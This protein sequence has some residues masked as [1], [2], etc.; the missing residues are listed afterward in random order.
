MQALL[1][2]LKGAEHAAAQSATVWAVN[3]LVQG[4]KSILPELL[5]AGTVETLIHC[6]QTHNGAAP[7]AV[8][9]LLVVFLHSGKHE[10]LRAILLA[11]P[12]ALLALLSML[13]KGPAL[14]PTKWTAS[15][16]STLCWQEVTMKQQMAE[17]DAPQVRATPPAPPAPPAP[18][19]ARR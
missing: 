5:Q 16:L 8:R 19:L 7:G 2:A 17:L 3:A 12:N 13:R 9:L 14:E 18:A 11:A 10:D 6:I 4:Q 1:S 15:L